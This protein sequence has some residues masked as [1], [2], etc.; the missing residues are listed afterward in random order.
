[1]CYEILTLELGMLIKFNKDI[2]G[3][4][5]DVWGMKSGDLNKKIIS[6]NL[7]MILY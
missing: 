4:S 5:P 3:H 6:E 7:K 2:S 1:M